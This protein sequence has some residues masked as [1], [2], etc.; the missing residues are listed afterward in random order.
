[1]LV[2]EPCTKT[3]A[4]CGTFNHTDQL[5]AT[6]RSGRHLKEINKKCLTT[7]S[8]NLGLGHCHEKSKK[9]RNVKS[10]SAAAIIASD[11]NQTS[12]L[13]NKSQIPPLKKRNETEIIK[14]IGVTANTT[15]VITFQ[16]YSPPIIGPPGPSGLPGPVGLPGPP[17]MKGAYEQPGMV[18]PSGPKG[19]VGHSGPPGTTGP[20]GQRKSVENPRIVALQEHMDHKSQ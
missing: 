17:G 16:P 8:G 11:T 6:D 3:S 10:L 5:M 9:R 18:C 15:N 14:S 7:K 20:H 4:I 12:S 1:M 19:I 2:L 13:V